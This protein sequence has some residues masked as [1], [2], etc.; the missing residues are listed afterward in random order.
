MRIEVYTKEQCNYCSMAKELLYNR[1]YLFEEHKLG[2]DFSRTF[3]KEKFPRAST[4]PVIVV[5]GYYIG[6]YSNLDNFLNL[7]ESHTD[8]RKYLVE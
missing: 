8:N 7:N 1:G 4:F 3:I 5:D 6:G 2:Q